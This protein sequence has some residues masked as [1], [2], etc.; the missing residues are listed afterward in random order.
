MINVTPG[1]HF[2]MHSIPSHFGRVLGQQIE[3]TVPAGKM[4]LFNRF[5]IKLF[6][7]SQAMSFD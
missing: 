7:G 1:G 6:I 5:K 3:L 2:M 4:K